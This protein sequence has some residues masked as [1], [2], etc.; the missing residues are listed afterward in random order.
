MLADW[1]SPSSLKLAM[2]GAMPA[3]ALISVASPAGA[4]GVREHAESQH[5]HEHHSKH[6]HE[7]GTQSQTQHSGGSHGHDHSG[8]HPSD[9]LLSDLPYLAV[10]F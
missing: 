10:P 6:V 8:Q 9:S 7:M 3:T 2:L 4:E 5:D 1:R